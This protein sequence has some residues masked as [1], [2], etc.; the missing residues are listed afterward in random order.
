MAKNKTTLLL[1][2]IL[3]LAWSCDFRQPDLTDESQINK[4]EA[5]LFL[6]VPVSGITA[7]SI[8]MPKVPV[9]GLKT[10]QSPNTPVR[11]RLVISAIKEIGT[12]EEGG[13]NRGKR[14]GQ[15][16]ASV[17]LGQGHPWCAAFTKFVYQ[18]NK[19]PT[20]GATAWS[21]SWFPKSRTYW[22]RGNDPATIQKADIFGLHYTNL[23]RIGH[24]GIIEKIDDNWLYTIE[25]NTGSDQGRDGDVV[26]RHRRSIRT[27]TK[28]SNW[29]DQ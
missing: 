19:I 8:S 25:G 9:S 20:P 7:E 29:A 5:S 6:Q 4:T 23:G 17:G 16:L 3:A 11:D 21:P 22:S 10:E 1:A 15:Y 2:G 13:N 24:V 26:R 14:I 27:I 18:E 12:R 28:I